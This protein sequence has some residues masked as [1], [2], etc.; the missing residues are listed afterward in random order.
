[1]SSSP[2]F[3]CDID[4][5]ITTEKQQEAAASAMQKL[6]KLQEPVEAG[7]L[8]TEFTNLMFHIHTYIYIYS[9]DLRRNIMHI[10]YIQACGMCIIRYC[11]SAPL[12]NI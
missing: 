2:C 9:R 8:V 10:L 12:M 1:M 5:H 4:R 7:D 3:T 6:Q 11:H